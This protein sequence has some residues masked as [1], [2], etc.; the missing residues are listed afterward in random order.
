MSVDADDLQELLQA[1]VDARAL[2]DPAVPVR[3]V[4]DAPAGTTSRPHSS[5]ARSSSRRCCTW[6]WRRTCSTR[7]AA[8]RSWPARARAALPARA[9]PTASSWTCCRSRRR[10]VEAFLTVEN[11]G[12]TDHTRERRRPAP[13]GRRHPHHISKAVVASTRPDDDRR[14]LRRDR[15]AACD[16]TRGEIGEDGAVL[17]RPGPPGRPRLLL[18]GRR[19]ADHRHRPR[20]RAARAGGDRRAGRGRHALRPIST[21]TAT[22]RTTTA[23]SSS[24]TG[25]A[26]RRRR[27]REPSGPRG[28]ST[29]RQLPDDAQPAGRRSC[30]RGRCATR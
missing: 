18:R 1:A 12:H 2:H 19:R 16:Q 22:S 29:T 26:T 24:S 7:S 15:R 14:V 3:A 17:R 11:P 28:E 23:S 10:R 9:A 27:R 6:C 30:P 5:S 8:S 4:L 21:P 20:L 25:G 13:I